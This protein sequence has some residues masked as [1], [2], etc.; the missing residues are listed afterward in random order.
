MATEAGDLPRPRTPPT[1][2]SLPCLSES[3]GKFGLPQELQ[4][5]FA[6]KSGQ[7]VQH[8]RGDLGGDIRRG[9]VRCEADLDSSHQAIPIGEQPLRGVQ[10]R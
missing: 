7:Q 8:R 2:V 9:P 3:H 5:S 6:G 10:T 4:P 1:A